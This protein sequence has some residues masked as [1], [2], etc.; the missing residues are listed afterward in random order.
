MHS[1]ITCEPVP[2][3]GIAVGVRATKLSAPPGAAPNGQAALAAALDLLPTGVILVSR[4]GTV[5][6]TNRGAAELLDRGDGLRVVQVRL[7]AATV[8]ESSTLWRLI[9]RASDELLRG[10]G[11]SSGDSIGA[12]KVSRRA[13]ATPLSVV[14]TPLRC[15]LE[16]PLDAQQASAA[17]FCSDPGRPLE[18]PQEMLA[19]LYG[20]T[21]A[22]TNLVLALL[23]GLDLGQAARRLSMSLS[24]ARCHLKHVFQKTG[25]NRQAELIRL[26]LSSPVAVRLL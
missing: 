7:S 18:T 3:Q 5:A 20:F 21:P 19:G 6:F 23:K 15:R 4:R 12:L 25:A 9:A 24:T 26:V 8:A 13:G 16:A 17:V 2:A 11:P 1:D 10:P 22:E 14:V